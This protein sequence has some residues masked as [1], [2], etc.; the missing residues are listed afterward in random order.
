[1][2]LQPQASRLGIAASHRAIAIGLL[3]VPL[4]AYWVALAEFV[5]NTH[6]PTSVSLFYNVVFCLT[7]VCLLNAPLRRWAPRIA[8]QPGELVTI[9]VLAAVGT[10]VAA[11]DTTCGLTAVMAYPGQYA[12]PEN[13]WADVALPLLPR[14]L[15][16]FDR[17]ALAGFWT[18]SS[19]LYDPANYR[20]WLGPLGRWAAFIALMCGGFL[21]QASLSRRRWIESERLTYPVA[22]VPLAMVATPERLSRSGAFWIAFGAAALI[23]VL[24]GLHVF[25]PAVPQIPVRSTGS[26]AFDIGAQILDLPWRAVGFLHL[27]FYPFIIGLGLLI[28]TELCF[29]C[30]FF[31]LLFKAQFVASQHFG[32]TA[33]E[34][35]PFPKE[36]SL[37][38]YLGFALFSLWLSRRYAARVLRAA[39]RPATQD[40]SGEL[41]TSRAAVVG[42]ALAFLGVIVFATRAGMS[43]WYATAFFVVYFLIVQSITRIRAEMGI[44]SH[45]LHYIAPGQL[46]PRVLGTRLAGA[47]NMATSYAFYWFNYAHRSHPMPHIAEACNLASHTG[48]RTR[49]LALP[50]LTAML[51]GALCGCWA[52]LHNYYQDG[53][54][55]KWSPHHSLWMAGPPMDELMLNLERQTAPNWRVV[56]AIAGG[57]AVAVFG[58]MARMRVGW[59][60]L[61]PIGCAV[62]SAWAMEHMW[63]ALLIAWAIKALVVRYGGQ[64]GFARARP[65]AMG[66]VIGEFAVGGFWSLYTLVTRTRTYTIWA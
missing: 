25:R 4:N 53:A 57:F 43:W 21:A 39:F 33:V 26:P 40:D 11:L 51:V 30:W 20:P 13:R 48:V 29:S 61:H 1:M 38:A 19:T 5:R 23:D 15:M 45:E 2:R 36:Q 56:A 55:A 47:R 16:V 17:A 27:S 8:L 35:M 46:L 28:P 12:S 60:P 54:A 49:S 24:N 31:Y 42:F 50:I 52:I 14:G 44:P 65:I 7:L 18:G 58:M 66:L 3:L 10:A 22:Q 34:G 6:Y 41:I 64:A 32:W 62:S 9:Y 37:G 59:W 63:F